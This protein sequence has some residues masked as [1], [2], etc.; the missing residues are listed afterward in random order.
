MQFL[1]G[2]KAGYLRFSSPEVSATSLAE[3][4]GRPEDARTIAGIKGTMKKVEGDE[5]TD[6]HKRVSHPLFYA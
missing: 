2:R 4:E 6:Y 3:F 5:E 1:D